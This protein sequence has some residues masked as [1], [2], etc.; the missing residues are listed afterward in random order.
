MKLI[1]KTESQS[2]KTLLNTGKKPRKKR[3]DE[4]FLREVGGSE[5]FG[6]K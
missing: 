3:L 5:S 6:S 4:P 2:P 1:V